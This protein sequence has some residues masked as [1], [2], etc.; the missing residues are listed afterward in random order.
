VCSFTSAAQRL[1]PLAYPPLSCAFCCH[2]LLVY[3]IA[4]KISGFTSIRDEETKTQYAYNNFGFVSFD[5]ERAICEK[6]E[7]AMDRN[8]NGYIIW[9]ISG[10]LMPDL[11]TPLL[12]ATNNR[13]NKTNARCEP[14]VPPTQTHTPSPF[15]E[16]Q[17][18]TT[19]PNV[20]TPNPTTP[21]NVVTTI[22]PK[23]D[24]ILFGRGAK[25][26]LNPGNIRLRELVDEY[27]PIYNRK[28][29]SSLY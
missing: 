3:N 15:V 8:L 17:K 10:D 4:S 23:D 5:D 2:V 22:I 18:P 6:T 12:D 16:G 27:R 20:I 24:D 19:T 28:F 25:G 9:E 1:I 26:R 11:S 21:N 14:A 29:P 13:L 7:Y